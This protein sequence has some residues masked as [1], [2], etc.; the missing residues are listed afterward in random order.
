MDEQSRV[1]RQGLEIEAH[2][3]EKERL[4]RDDVGPGDRVQRQ[5]AERDQEQQAEQQVVGNLADVPDAGNHDPPREQRER[6]RPS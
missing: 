1:G 4:G 6:A 2:E 5:P 3:A